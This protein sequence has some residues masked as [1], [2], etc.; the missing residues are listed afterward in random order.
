MAC[1][2]NQPQ[3]K[4]LNCSIIISTN[5]VEAFLLLYQHLLWTSVVYTDLHIHAHF[6]FIRKSTIYYNGSYICASVNL[7]VYEDAVAATKNLEHT[8]HMAA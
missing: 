3:G 5:S 4:K 6:V 8:T 7:A 2:Q 1:L